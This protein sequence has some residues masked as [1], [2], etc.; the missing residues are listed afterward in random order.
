MKIPKKLQCTTM[1]DA[2]ATAA[3]IVDAIPFWHADLMAA[4]TTLRKKTQA[5]LASN[6]LTPDGRHLL[7]ILDYFFDT[8]KDTG[9]LLTHALSFL[10]LKPNGQYHIEIARKAAEGIVHCSGLKFSFSKNNPNNKK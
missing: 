3:G 9:K 1:E 6:K 5:L 10:F 4:A 2:L 7:F 8:Y